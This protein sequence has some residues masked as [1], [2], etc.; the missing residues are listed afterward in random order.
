[1]GIH[2]LLLSN[3]NPIYISSYAVRPKPVFENAV[4][5]TSIIMM[6]KTENRCEHLYATKMYRRDEGKFSLDSLMS[7][8]QYTDVLDYMLIGRIPK[9][10][11]EIEKSILS[12]LSKLT[13][14]STF[15]DAEGNP[16][17]YRTTGGRYFKIVTNYSTGSTKEK[18]I[19]L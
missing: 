5:N 17:F 3:C 19:F 2:R 13:K 10:G 7:N 4:V 11:L 9:I 8:I 14:L 16:I 15:L 12:K 1:M 6:R 18:A